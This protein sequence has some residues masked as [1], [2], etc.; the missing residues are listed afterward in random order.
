VWGSAE[1]PERKA[2]VLEALLDKWRSKGPGEY[3]VSG[4]GSATFRRL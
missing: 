2:L 1:N 3:D 4:S